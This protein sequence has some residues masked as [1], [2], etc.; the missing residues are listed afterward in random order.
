MLCNFLYLQISPVKY[1]NLSANKHRPEHRQVKLKFHCWR[2][3]ASILAETVNIDQISI[4]FLFF[5]S[6]YAI[7]NTSSKVSSK[8]FKA[9]AWE[10][11]SNFCEVNFLHRC[12]FWLFCISFFEQRNHTEYII[13]TMCSDEQHQS[14]NNGQWSSART[15]TPPIQQNISLFSHKK[16]QQNL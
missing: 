2:H 3:V 16:K 9:G 1:Y 10:R 11:E 13:Y 8:R 5:V 4:V 7:S 6:F 15:W 14:V 12:P